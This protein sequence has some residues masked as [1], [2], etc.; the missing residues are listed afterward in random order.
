MLS[1][2]NIQDNNTNNVK[3][4]Q[5]NNQLIFVADI[6]PWTFCRYFANGEYD[7]IGK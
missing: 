3:N 1:L 4:I 2:K 7:E 5:N 6:D